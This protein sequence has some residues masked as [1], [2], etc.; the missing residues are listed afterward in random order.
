MRS[1]TDIANAPVAVDMMGGGRTATVFLRGILK[2]LRRFSD[3]RSRFV[4]VGDDCVLNPIVN[5]L[6]RRYRR[7]LSVMH[8]PH[9]IGGDDKPSQAVRS[10]ATDS[11][12]HRAVMAVASGHARACLSAGNSGVLLGLAQKYLGLVA[13]VSRPA[14][15]CRV[16]TLRGYSYMLDVGG[17]VDLSANRLLQ[18]ARTATQSLHYT[19]HRPSVGLLN[20]GVES[21]KGTAVIREAD[22]LLRADPELNYSGFIEGHSLFSGAVDVIL[23][24][25]FVGNLVLKSLEG[26]SDYM[27]KVLGQNLLVRV[28]YPVLRYT[29]A[30]L[31]AR[32]Y[33][34]AA[35]LGLRGLVVKSHSSADA[36]AFSYAVELAAQSLWTHGQT[37]A[38]AA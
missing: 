16:P 27:L 13:G 8:A 36:L 20:I 26:S 17:T 22:A 14:I 25:G 6:A 33:N 31:D 28:F 30:R 15:C 11:S 21:T 2:Y 4:L 5:A 10:E 19:T 1:K 9:V 34:G 3:Q 18:L 12:M 23:C 24:E 7:Y 32:R 38:R 35:L 29:L 37:E